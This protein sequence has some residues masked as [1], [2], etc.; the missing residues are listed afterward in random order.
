MSIYAL[1]RRPFPLSIHVNLNTAAAAPFPFQST[2]ST[3]FFAHQPRLIN[4]HIHSL[5]RFELLNSGRLR[6]PIIP[7]RG[8]RV[9]KD[10]LAR[11]HPSNADQQKKLSIASLLSPEG[12]TQT[13]QRQQSPSTASVSTTVSA[14]PVS[15]LPTCALEANQGTYLDKPAPTAPHQLDSPSSVV[16]ASSQQSSK[17]PAPKRTKAAARQ[18]N[19]QCDIE[20]LD[21]K[22]VQVPLNTSSG[23]K[24]PN[25]KRKKKMEACETPPAPQQA[26]SAA[27]QSHGI[28]M[29]QV[30]LYAVSDSFVTDERRQKNRAAS[31]QSRERRKR[32]EAFLEK[33]V[34]F[35]HKDRNEILSGIRDGEDPERLLQRPPS[36]GTEETIPKKRWQREG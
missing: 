27:Y 9:T 1:R 23:S 19:A 22:G 17:P 13:D 26:D 24:A 7:I 31:V 33:Q 10:P 34:A 36:P 8:P 14:T 29:F 11:M 18:S 21:G 12:D 5:E 2:S 28:E 25:S 30:P 15:S 20:M 3:A 32:R 4:I 16:S 35:Y 6:L